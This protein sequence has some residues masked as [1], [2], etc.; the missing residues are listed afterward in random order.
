MNNSLP[1]QK[2]AFRKDGN[3]VMKNAPFSTQ[4]NSNTTPVGGPKGAFLGG[5]A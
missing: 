3:P 4:N 1:M 5:S 2:S